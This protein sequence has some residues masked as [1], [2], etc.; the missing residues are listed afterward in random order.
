MCL[1]LLS[2]YHPHV[3]YG[4]RA[5]Y[6]IYTPKEVMLDKWIRLCDRHPSLAYYEVIG[7]SI[8]GRDIY[9]FAI[10]TPHGGR[11]MYD[12]QL[13]GWED[14]G[15]EC[16]YMFAE[17]LL[18]SSDPKALRILQQNFNLFIP[19][20]NVDTT[21]RQNMRREYVLPNGTI[22][23]VPYGVDLNRN[24]VY[25]WGRSGSGDPANNYNYRGLA[26]ASEPETQALHFAL[27][28]Y[29]PRIYL[30]THLG[31][32][33]VRHRSNTP[34]E[35]AIKGLIVAYSAELGVT[36]YAMRHGLGSGLVATDADELFGASGWLIEIESTRNLPNTLQ[37]F[38][39]DYY[40]RLFAMFLA[41]N[42]ATEITAPPISE[43][44]ST[45]H[46]MMA[47]AITSVIALLA[48]TRAR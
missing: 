24:G 45:I 42:Q 29:H 43:D 28:K 8:Q 15:T 21:N 16:L 5:A 20:V 40:P 14:G 11:V 48:K 10:G 17:W 36:P 35:D 23:S 3:A 9:L 26:P 19:I 27:E 32:A 31:A 25:G 46:L 2:T 39:Q 4:A 13:H 1:T 33:Y 47:F 37:A 38:L 41:F 34:F 44:F 18:E 12:G 30:N 22:I 6:S 7:Q